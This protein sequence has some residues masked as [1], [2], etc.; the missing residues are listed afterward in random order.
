MGLRASCLVNLL[1]SRAVK[2]VRQR[3]GREERNERRGWATVGEC[4]K[5][6]GNEEGKRGD[7]IFH[8]R[9]S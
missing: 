2:R 8:A 3:K 7:G 1:A 5:G 4:V 9:S 6:G